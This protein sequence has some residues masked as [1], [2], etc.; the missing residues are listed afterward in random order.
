MLF[1]CETTK[2]VVWCPVELG[3]LLF[4]QNLLAQI[5]V[6][7]LHFPLQV[8]LFWVKSGRFLQSLFYDLGPGQLH[9]FF[10]GCLLLGAL[11]RLGLE[12]VL[13][14]LAVNVFH[15]LQ[16]LLV[17]HKAASV[18]TV[19]AVLPFVLH[20]ALRSGTLGTLASN[21]FS[22]FSGHPLSTLCFLE[23]LQLYLPNPRF[24]CELL[25]VGESVN[26]FIRLFFRL[27]DSPFLLQIRFRFL[28]GREP[29]QSV[30]SRHIHEI[31]RLFGWPQWLDLQNVVSVPHTRPEP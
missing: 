28:G 22:E 26:G 30:L 29:F 4:V 17:Y 3:E 15:I 1:C 19:D 16:T 27:L 21:P 24:Y 2:V 13:D 12:R 8:F 14:L 5:L 7:L 23:L 9:L 31:E 10:P 11:L 25:K 6:H 18:R 20:D